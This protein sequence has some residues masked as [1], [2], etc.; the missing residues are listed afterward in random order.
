M[1]EQR[2]AGRPSIPNETILAEV[3][4]SPE[5][6]EVFIEC[7]ERLVSSKE[8][9]QTKADLYK[10]DVKSTAETFGLGSGF[11]SWIATTVAKGDLETALEE[12]SAKHEV[13]E[14][15]KN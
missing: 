2:K 14:L 12:L 7:L 6:R 13:I 15:F 5:K 9:L 1:T 8:A 11:V 4:S 10:D 3:L